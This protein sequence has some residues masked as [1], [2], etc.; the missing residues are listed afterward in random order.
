MKKLN[1]K[2]MNL[3]YIN[4]VLAMVLIAIIF[5]II[6]PLVMTPAGK[7]AT[8]VIREKSSAGQ[9]APT[10]YDIDKVK[11]QEGYAGK[12]PATLKEMY[13]NFPKSDV[14]GDAP[15]A[16]KRVSIADKEK[17]AQGLDNEI[18]KAKDILKT[19]PEDKNAK[20]MLFIAESLKKI[21]QEDFN[22][23]IKK[24]DSK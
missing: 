19:N 11:Q 9:V 7:V 22:Y 15:Q 10:T 4:I 21:T 14:G 5:F 16:W 18:E 6:K 12:E 17:I 3:L 24:T 1:N 2:G 20:N 13:E 8:A 23:R